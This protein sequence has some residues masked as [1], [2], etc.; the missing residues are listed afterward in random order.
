MLHSQSGLETV[1]GMM[2]TRHARR[3]LSSLIFS[4]SLSLSIYHISPGQFIKD[5]LSSIYNRDNTLF[6]RLIVPR[7]LPFFLVFKGKHFPKYE[8]LSKNNKVNHHHYYIEISSSI[9][10]DDFKNRSINLF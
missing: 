6:L 7:D 10:L 5:W 4:L 8:S 1:S 9:V 2:M 3:R